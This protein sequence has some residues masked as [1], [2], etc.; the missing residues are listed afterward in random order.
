MVRAESHSY[1]QQ[2]SKTN[3]PLTLVSKLI[4]AHTSAMPRPPDPEMTRWRYRTTGN[5][6]EPEPWPVPGGRCRSTLGP[7]TQQILRLSG[8][9]CS[10]GHLVS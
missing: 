8:K 6:Y 2:C 3:A 4:Y 1:V 9:V 10:E 5:Q 7:T